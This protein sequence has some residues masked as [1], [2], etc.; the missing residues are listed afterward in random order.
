MYCPECGQEYREGVTVCADCGVALTSDP[1]PT[2]REPSAEWLDLETVLE[3][4]DAAL[5]LVVRSLL[6]AEGIPCFARGEF[7]Q[8]FLGWGR[9][10]SGANL[11]TG[12][13]QLQVPKER[14][15]EAR[16]LLE[17]ADFAAREAPADESVEE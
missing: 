12:P 1:P 3:T 7:L 17:T 8:E 15:E 11:V 2:P 9:L 6:E 14:S 4:S 10:A 16:R 5:L 13:V